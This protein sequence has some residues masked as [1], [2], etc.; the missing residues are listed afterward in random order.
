MIKLRYFIVVLGVVLAVAFVRWRCTS[1]CPHGTGMIGTTKGCCD[2]CAVGAKKNCD[3]ITR[4]C[5][6]CVSDE[7][8]CTFWLRR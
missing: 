6:E 4:R 5:D 1:E 3:K 8:S 2:G 7:P